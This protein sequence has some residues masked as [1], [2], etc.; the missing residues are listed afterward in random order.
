MGV[1]SKHRHAVQSN[2]QDRSIIHVFMLRCSRRCLD[3]QTDMGMLY[4][5]VSPAAL[6]KLL[7]VCA[8]TSLGYLDLAGRL[9]D[10]GEVVFM[11]E[12]TFSMQLQLRAGCEYEL[13]SFPQK[14]LICQAQG[15]KPLCRHKISMMP[16][17]QK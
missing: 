13:A 5:S 12:S 4:Q 15:L 9:C 2:S 7:L 16:F 1:N 11:R 8:G 17:C 14:P 10:A 3:D 6:R